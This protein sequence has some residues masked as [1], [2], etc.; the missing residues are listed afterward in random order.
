MRILRVFPRR[1]SMTPNDPLVFIGDP[2]LWRPYADQVH[3]SVTFTW[4]M[5]EGCRLGQAWNQYY[6]NVRIGGPAYGDSINSH[7]FRPGFYIR[8]GVT[9]TTVGCDNDCPWCLVS[10]REGQLRE[11]DDFAP[12]WIIQDNN[13][14]QASR[15]HI[16]QV[17]QMLK[18]QKMGATFS[19]GFDPWLV[20]DWLAE[21]LRGLRINQLFLSA[22]TDAHLLP[23]QKAIKKLS[24][25][26]KSKLRVY[27]LIGFG[28]QTIQ[29]AEARLERVW[30]LGGMPFAQLYQPESQ[31]IDYS[32][33]WKRLNRKWSRPAAM[34]ASH[35]END[36]VET[37]QETQ[38]ILI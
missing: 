9:F 4:D 15:S 1:T 3:V 11:L 18:Q 31:Y 6:E 8:P 37:Q 22:D 7:P 34:V 23:L 12:G 20:D 25:L 2:P 33:E 10:D 26:P 27:T 21:E 28:N 24:Y 36:H 14:L 35:R 13:L 17:F 32:S 16:L 5:K 29:Q 30:E 19:G 38:K